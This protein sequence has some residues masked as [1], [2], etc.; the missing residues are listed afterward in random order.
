MFWYLRLRQCYGFGTTALIGRIEI[1][2]IRIHADGDSTGIV[3]SH[4]AR[5]ESTP[6]GR[7]LDASTGSI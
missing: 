1:C 7:V 6:N 2:V 4:R 3:S 5:L